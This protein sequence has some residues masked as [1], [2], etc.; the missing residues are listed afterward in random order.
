MRPRPWRVVLFTCLHGAVTLGFLLYA[1][2]GLARLDGFEAPHGAATAAIAADV[3]ILPGY[4][5]WTPWASKNLPNVVEW[6]L[7]VANSALWGFVISLI[8]GV[9][10]P[11]RDRSRSNKPYGFSL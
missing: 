11:R 5:L 8:A 3:L 2:Q 4:L 6:L 1:M 7:F 10:S 9:M